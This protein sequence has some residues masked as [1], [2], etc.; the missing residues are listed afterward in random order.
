MGNTYRLEY[1]NPFG[2]PLDSF[3]E[4]EQVSYQRTENKVGNMDILVKADINKYP[5]GYWKKDGVFLLM[6]SI[7]GGEFYNDTNTA[8]FINQV[9]YPTNK[10]GELQ[11][12]INCTDAL[13]VLKRRLV[14]YESGNVFSEKEGFSEEMMKDFIRD[15]LGV[16]TLD[17]DR[18]ASQYITIDMTEFN[19]GGIQIKSAAWAE[20]FSTVSEIAKTSEELIGRAMIFDLVY[21]GNFNFLFKVWEDYRGNDLR[22]G[23]PVSEEYGTLAQ[24]QVLLDFESEKN[25]IYALSKGTDGDQTVINAVAENAD[26]S[27]FS[28]KE[29][30]IQAKYQYSDAAVQAEAES[31]LL[32]QRAQALFSG[33]L[34]QTKDFR[35]GVDFNYGDILSAQYLGYTFDVRIK[36]VNVT[37]NKSGE[38]VLCRLEGKAIV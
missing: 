1:L 4:F 22:S 7:D 33:I 21:R 6:R 37:V 32:D 13:G 35:Y 5:L 18:S 8:W 36:T 25:S 38:Q 34:Q 23:I 31:A 14:A 9:R 20:L 19:R 24:P 27:P 2:V 12:H 3:V 11:I 28:R 10:N 17:A 16:G 26:S 29:A 30:K 15:N